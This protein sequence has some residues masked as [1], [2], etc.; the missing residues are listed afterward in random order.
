MASGRRKYCAARKLIEQARF[1]HKWGD[2]SQSMLQYSSSAEILTELKEEQ[3]TESEKKEIDAMIYSCM[4]WQKMEE[5]ETESSVDL[6]NEAAKLFSKV[7]ESSTKQK[8]SLIS[9][10][11][12]NFCLAMALGLK[13]RQ[14]LELED[15]KRAKSHLVEASN[16]YSSAGIQE[17]VGWFTATERVLDAYVYIIKAPLETD[18]E[19]RAKNYGLA[20]EILK[21]SAAIFDHSGYRGKKNEILAALGKIRSEKEFALSLAGMLGEPKIVTS[22]VTFSPPELSSEDSLRLSELK[23]PNIQIALSFPRKAVAGEHFTVK[24]DLINTG[25][26]PATLHKIEG[27]LPSGTMLD[28]DGQKGGRGIEESSSGMM[29]FE[30]KRFLPLQMDTFSYTVKLKSNVDA[31]EFNPKVYYSDQSGKLWIT[32]TDLQRLDTSRVLD[33]NFSEKKTKELFDCLVKSFIKDL[34]IEKLHEDRSGWRTISQISNDIGMSS[35]TAYGKVKGGMGL[36]FVELQRLGLMETRM[37]PGER[38]RGGNVTK[39][40]IAYSKEPIRG[41]IRQLIG[42]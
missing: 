15:Y 21:Q 17:V 14:S 38:G 2:V 10:G 28:S 11:N 3:G 7:H 18:P 12:E 1:S 16:C 23:R 40:R 27:L 41:H 42:H 36:V 33:L 32:Q 39:I 35:S 29:D 37:F 22:P 31:L 5:A 26:E 19:A 4:A 13:F 20:E 24:V 30:G 9:R 8:S 25:K 6:F 34:T